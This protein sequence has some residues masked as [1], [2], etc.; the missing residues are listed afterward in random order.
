MKVEEAYIIECS[1][2]LLLVSSL[3]GFGT[4]LYADRIISV[5]LQ[6]CAM[7]LPPIVAYRD[8]K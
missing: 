1:H 8:A 5:V 4:C 3:S 2:L 7:L 6:F